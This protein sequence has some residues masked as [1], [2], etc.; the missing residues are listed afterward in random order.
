MIYAVLDYSS[1]LVLPEL[2]VYVLEIV[3]TAT[4]LFF[5]NR[6]TLRFTRMYCN[7]NTTVSPVFTK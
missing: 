3:D 2:F 5:F 4:Y 6:L 7:Q 1:A